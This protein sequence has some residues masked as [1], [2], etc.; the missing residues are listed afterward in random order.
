MSSPVSKYI[1]E[2]LV[3]LCQGIAKNGCTDQ[4]LLAAVFNDDDSLTATPDKT[5]IQR[6]H[7][8]VRSACSDFHEE[9]GDRDLPSR[10]L[11]QDDLNF[12]SAVEQF[13]QSC[14]PSGT[15]RAEARPPP[16]DNP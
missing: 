5:P 7:D 10:A 3:R 4:R 1:D 15:A 6:V 9:V 12:I 13:V 16:G 8:F 11:F 14:L 2:E